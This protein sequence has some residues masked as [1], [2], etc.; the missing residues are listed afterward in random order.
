MRS[1]GGTHTTPPVAQKKKKRRSGDEK[2][3]TAWPPAAGRPKKK[4]VRFGF[5]LHPFLFPRGGV[6]WQPAPAFS[7]PPPPILRPRVCGMACARWGCVARCVDT[8]FERL[9][10]FF[11]AAAAG[12]GWSGGNKKKN[13]NTHLL[14]KHPSPAGAKN[15]AFSLTLGSGEGLPSQKKNEH[16]RASLRF[17]TLENPFLSSARS[18]ETPLPSEHPRACR[19]GRRH[20][21]TCL[22]ARRE[23]APAARG[24]KSRRKP[25]SRFVRAA[26]APDAGSPVSRRRP[27][28]SPNPPRAQRVR[29]CVSVV[30]AGVGGG[31]AAGGRRPATAHPSPIAGCAA[32]T[33]GAEI[34]APASPHPPFARCLNSKHAMKRD[35]CGA[36]RGASRRA[37]RRISCRPWSVSRFG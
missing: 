10:S 12:G 25:D 32:P 31:E 16:G 23:T 2:R 6:S 4:S 18:L 26:F 24:A 20:S 3:G 9:A 27:P 13:E 30:H 17:F 36:R 35:R 37:R 7:H 29:H 34:G 8:P 22:S 5:G 28:S 1:R 21:G 33:A 19:H 11:F 14:C 15:G